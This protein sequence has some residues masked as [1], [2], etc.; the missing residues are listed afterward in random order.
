MAD[1]MELFRADRADL[2]A[3]P[4]SIFTITATGNFRY[5]ED[6]CQNMIDCVEAGG[7]GSTGP[8]PPMG[9]NSPVSAGGATAF[10]TIL[11][12]ARTTTAP[13]LPPRAPLPF[14]WGPATS[15]T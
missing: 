8:G 5:S 13:T 1:M 9:L 7:A 15:P 6:S 11:L 4:M 12:L 3:R 2:I 10:H 14:S